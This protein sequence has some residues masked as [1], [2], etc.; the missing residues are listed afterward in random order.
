MGETGRH[1]LDKDHGV[2]CGT[3]FTQ[4]SGCTVGSSG[5]QHDLLS[6]LH[7]VHKMNYLNFM[8]VSACLRCQ[9]R[10]IKPMYFLGTRC[11]IWLYQNL[12]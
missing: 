3:I 9:Q 2:L 8:G 6:A 10:W 1:A 7:V 11:C 12:N 4:Y 5:A